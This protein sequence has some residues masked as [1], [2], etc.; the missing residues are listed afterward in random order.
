VAL[1]QHTPYFTHQGRI[2]ASFRHTH[3]TLTQRWLLTST[4]H[5]ACQ[6]HHQLLHL[7]FFGAGE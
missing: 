6:H 3:F 5:T 4:L 1:A 7:L 2:R